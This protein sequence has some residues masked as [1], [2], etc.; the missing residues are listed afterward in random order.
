MVQDVHLEQGIVVDDAASVPPQE[1]RLL[2]RGGAKP[3]AMAEQAR[4]RP[5]GDRGARVVAGEEERREC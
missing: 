4:R 5:C 1:E 2:C 3:L